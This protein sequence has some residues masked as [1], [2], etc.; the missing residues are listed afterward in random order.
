MSDAFLSKYFPPSKTST[1]RAQIINFRQRGGESL[2]EAW[3]RYQELLRL[4]PH[5]GLE[6]W[7]ILQIFYEGLEQS[8]KLTIDATAGG[9]LMNMSA[10]DAY[11]LIDEMALGQQQWS[12]V[13]GPVR[14]APGLIETDISTKLAAQLEAI[15]KS[16]D[17]LTNQNISVVHQSPTC[18]ICDGGDHLAINYNWGRSA[19]GDAE[20]VNAFN[21]NFRPQNNPYSNIYNPGWRNHSNFYQDNQS[22]NPNQHPNQ[23]RPIQGYGQKQFNQGAPQKSNME[24]MMERVMRGQEEF[25]QDQRR[26]NQ[27]VADQINDLSMKIDLLW[28]TGNT[29]RKNA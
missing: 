23:N 17:R 19:E 22:Q 26:I 1:L 8:S 2:S 5:H 29:S 3:D 10:R 28:S 27:Q 21:N 14:G 13:R 24:Q 6:K 25:M 18:A 16:I 20:Q 4:C 7:F 9:N 15:Q 12:S 11:K